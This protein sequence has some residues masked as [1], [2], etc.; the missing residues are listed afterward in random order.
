[1]HI[2]FATRVL[3]YP[4]AEW[5][6]VVEYLRSYRE[7]ETFRVDKVRTKLEKVPAS[8]RPESSEAVELLLVPRILFQISQFYI[9]IPTLVPTVKGRLRL[10]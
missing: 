3:D 4:S 2:F 7:E 10:K 9:T 5:D 8:R 6:V 1:M